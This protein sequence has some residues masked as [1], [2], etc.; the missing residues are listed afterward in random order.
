MK[1]D[2]TPGVAGPD[3][4]AIE[5]SSFAPILIAWQRAHGRQTLPWQ[6]LG[7]ARDAYRVWLAEVML[8]QTQ[9]A[10]VIPFY[11]RFL[12]RFPDIRVLAEAPLDDVMQHWGGLGYYSRARNLH[13]AARRVVSDFGGVFPDS[14]D[15]LESLPGIGRSTAG[16]I[17]AFAYGRRAAILDGNVKRVLARIFLI[18]GPPASSA[19][20]KT[21]W[22]LSESLLPDRDIE[23][24]TQGLMDLGA[25]VCTPRRPACLLCPFERVC[26]AHRD[27][28][29]T[30]LPARATR[31]TVPEREATLLLV[32]RGGS[33]LLE[34]RPAVGIWGGLWS[35][36]EVPV[37]LP[38]DASRFGMVESIERV[39]GFVH[40]F[41]HFVLHARVEHVRVSDAARTVEAPA[42]DRR[43]IAF[44]ALDSIGLPT[45]IRSLLARGFD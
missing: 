40:A 16:A 20:T 36:P 15:A 37:N 22:A 34:R 19:M 21:L 26:L 28:R 41:T 31:R 29:E 7:V 13:A 38:L 45:P 2:A 3:A 23:R 30:S 17:A 14:V 6:Q 43:W 18:E 4:R 12:S 8:Q 27:G 42:D 24:Y 10:A 9:V 1:A 25:T 5:P 32:T 44:D 39:A 35:L 33:V 11:E